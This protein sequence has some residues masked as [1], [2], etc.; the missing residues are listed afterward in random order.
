MDDAIRDALKGEVSPAQGPSAEWVIPFL[1]TE[2]EVFPTGDFV[3]N[4]LI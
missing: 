3:L 1:Y 2:D 4:G